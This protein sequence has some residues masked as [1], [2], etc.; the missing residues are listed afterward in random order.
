[1]VVQL[2]LA[3]LTAEQVFQASHE[4]NLGY[5]GTGKSASQD[6]AQKC[7]KIR[8]VVALTL[9]SC[10]QCVFNTVDQT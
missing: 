2:L 10:R 9:V 7:V 1:M 4:P 3:G 8:D 5:I 6:D